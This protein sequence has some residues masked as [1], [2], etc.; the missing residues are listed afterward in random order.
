MVWHAGFPLL[1]LG[2]AL[3]KDQDGG[4]KIKGSV[5]SSI[6]ASAVAIGVAIFAITWVT[7]AR[8]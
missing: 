4:A 3:L 1:V 2:Y 7:T 6:L 5:A 8:L